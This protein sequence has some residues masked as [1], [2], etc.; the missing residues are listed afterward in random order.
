MIS[1]KEQKHIL[2][3]PTYSKISNFF[4]RCFSL[5]RKKYRT[6]TIVLKY[7]KIS[8]S[9]GVTFNGERCASMKTSLFISTDIQQRFIKGGDLQQFVV[10][11][12]QLLNPLDLAARTKTN[13]KFASKT[14]VLA[15]QYL[16]D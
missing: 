10:I 13:R 3:R 16:R 11:C 2:S 14:Y 15:Y 1:I 4:H 5:V 6:Y 12:W 9:G 7:H 8:S